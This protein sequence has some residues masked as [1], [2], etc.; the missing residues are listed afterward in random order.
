M[1]SDLNGSPAQPGH[2][3]PFG[4]K[5]CTAEVAYADEPK[6]A[7]T[8]DQPQQRGP[9]PLRIGVVSADL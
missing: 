1:R 2:T 6:T 5:P 9:R 8:I 3:R 4:A 7:M